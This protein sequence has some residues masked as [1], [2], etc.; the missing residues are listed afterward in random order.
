M[1]VSK[2]PLVLLVPFLFIFSCATAHKEN[3]STSTIQLPI[4][5]VVQLAGKSQKEI[6]LSSKRWIAESFSSAKAVTQLDS[7]ESGEILLKGY[8]QDGPIGGLGL[9]VPVDF[10]L[11][12][13][14]KDGKARLTFSDIWLNM[15]PQFPRREITS[16]RMISE[17]KSKT[18]NIVAKYQAF[19]MTKQ[20]KEDW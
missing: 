14:M 13:E 5:S 4:E 20:K 9:P 7:P 16:P 1:S 18:E 6:Y 2:R 10:T 8:M 17:F 3:S 11:L 19:I 15:G 12:I